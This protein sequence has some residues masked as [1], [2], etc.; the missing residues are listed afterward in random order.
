LKKRKAY[1]RLMY[2][3]R[4]RIEILCREGTPITI[5]AYKIGVDPMTIRRELKRGGDP[6]SAE[7]AQRSV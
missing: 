7:A 6:Y 5:M 1:K 3:D 2:E 4:K